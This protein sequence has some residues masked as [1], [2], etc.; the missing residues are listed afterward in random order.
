MSASTTSFR[1]KKVETCDD[2]MNE[3]SIEFDKYI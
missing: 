1:K 2:K 3:S